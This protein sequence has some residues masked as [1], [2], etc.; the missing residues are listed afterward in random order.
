ML[1]F[2]IATLA[3][4]CCGHVTVSL[5]F[6]AQ[7]TNQKIPSILYPIIRMDSAKHAAVAWLRWNRFGLEEDKESYEY[8]WT[9][10]LKPWVINDGLTTDQNHES[11]DD[12]PHAHA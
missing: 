12:Q 9:L 10:V 6:L 5:F 11:A 2:V 1:S 3:G 4:M 8:F 7:G